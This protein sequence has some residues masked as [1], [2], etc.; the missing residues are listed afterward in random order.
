MI[1]TYFLF[2]RIYFG[3][4][5]FYFCTMGFCFFSLFFSFQWNVQFF[6]LEFILIHCSSSICTMGSNFVT[7]SL[8]NSTKVSKMIILIWSYFIYFCTKCWII[9]TVV[10][11]ICFLWDILLVLFYFVPIVN[12]IALSL[13]IVP[14][15][16]TF[17]WCCFSLFCSL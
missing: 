3:K 6:L 7:L 15:L 12:F 14:L 8:L 5:F 1:F 2:Y 13:F 10:G 16:S 17:M 11:L 9:F 4:L